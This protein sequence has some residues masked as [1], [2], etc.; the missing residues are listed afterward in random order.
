MEQS[1]IDKESDAKALMCTRCKKK[2]FDTDLIIPFWY[3][4]PMKICYDCYDYLFEM[5][6]K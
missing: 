6:S 4:V 5:R 1:R 2:A 3:K